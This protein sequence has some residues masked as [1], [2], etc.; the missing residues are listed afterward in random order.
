MIPWTSNKYYKG[1]GN[2]GEVKIVGDY[3]Y[4]EGAPIARMMPKAI[5]TVK[6]RFQEAILNPEISDRFSVVVTSNNMT[7]GYV[8]GDVM[9][10]HIMGKIQAMMK[11]DQHTE[12]ISTDEV[13]KV[14]C[15]VFEVDSEEDK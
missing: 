15:E 5:A 2:M 9:L 12:L 7:A 8:D 11:E 1:T 3:I 10:Q 14:L 6:D 13:K 4:F